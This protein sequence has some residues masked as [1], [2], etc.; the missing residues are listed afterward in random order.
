MWMCGSM[1]RMVVLPGSVKFERRLPVDALRRDGI[2]PCAMAIEQAARLGIGRAAQGQHGGGALGRPAGLEHPAEIG[3]QGAGRER[4]DA[5]PEL[6][7][8]GPARCPRRA[9]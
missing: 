8:Y 5:A 6:R 9:L 1:K 3:Q 4:S 7:A 2:A